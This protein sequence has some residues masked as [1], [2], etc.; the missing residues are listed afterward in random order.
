MKSYRGKSFS[1]NLRHPFDS[2]L[3]EG[4]GTSVHRL[5]CRTYRY[6][7]LKSWKI[8]TI[9]LTQQFS[10]SIFTDFRYQSLKIYLIAIY[11]YRYRF[12]SI[13]YSGGTRKIN[14]AS[15][16]VTCRLGWVLTYGDTGTS[17]RYRKITSSSF[18]YKLEAERKVLK[19]LWRWRMLQ[20]C[21]LFLLPKW[22][23]KLLEISRNQF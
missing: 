9:D 20:T 10:L 5:Q 3:S 8:D 7:S 14:S 13:D 1:L 11:F 19:D 16:F 21:S 6:K 2:I 4:G 18:G 17:R 23:R 22:G 12:L 15:K